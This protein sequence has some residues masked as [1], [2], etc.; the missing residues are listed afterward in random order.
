MAD[1]KLSDLSA[2]ASLASTDLFY[3]V[4]TAG[5]G[6]VK[7]TLSQLNTLY[8]GLGANTFT[9]TQTIPSLT[10][11]RPSDN[12]SFNWL[13]LTAPAGRTHE[14]PFQIYVGGATFSSE[15]DPVMYFGYN[16]DRS[17]A[18]EPAFRWV[19]E[20]NY[21]TGS[22]RDIEAYWEYVDTAANAWRPI[23]VYRDKASVT[24]G[25]ET[26]VLNNEYLYLQGTRAAPLTFTLKPQNANQPAQ[27][28][29][30]G[31][32]TGNNTNQ[33]LKIAGGSSDSNAAFIRLGGNTCTTG[34]MGGGNA[35]EGLLQLGAGAPSTH[36]AGTTSGTIVMLAGATPTQYFR[37]QYDGKIAINRAGV[38]ASYQVDVNGD[39]GA[40]SLVT[41]GTIG[42]TSALGTT[43]DVYLQRDAANVLTQRNSTTAQKFSVA[44]TWTDASNYERG[45][46][47]WSGNTFYVG[48]EKAGTGSARAMSFAIDGVGR[49]GIGTSFDFSPSS[50]KSYQIGYNGARVKQLFLGQ[51]LTG[52]SATSEVD[53]A[54]TWNTSGTPTLI[55]ANITDTASNAASLF[56]DFQVAGSSK[57]AIHKSGAIR[58]LST[59]V[60]SLPTAANAGAGARAFVTDAN[61]TTFL[62]TVAGGG[63]NKVPVV[64]DGTN[65]I[66]G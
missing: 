22:E 12:S 42:I 4:K 18:T 53:I 14:A 24:T 57:A 15:W 7:A 66:I 65:W 30:Q 13:S 5:S 60:A 49:W 31:L 40:T 11:Q 45:F 33:F 34:E 17:N 16:A 27:I 47:W 6:G 64:S 58:T 35:A 8:A 20:G 28:W 56:A 25:G 19:I 21:N 2:A 43:P 26:L 37:L 10:Y 50:D 9:S 46:L 1:S 39:L 48:N 38:A 36:T 52:S 61:S 29:V 59:T 32:G 51:S 55:L 41:S 23:F 44:N 54:T 3:V 62:S 63:A